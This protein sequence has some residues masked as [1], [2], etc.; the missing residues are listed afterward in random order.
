VYLGAYDTPE[1][2]ASAYDRAALAYWGE[3]AQLNVSTRLLTVFACLQDHNLSI[4][5]EM[6]GYY[7]IMWQLAYVACFARQ[8]SNSNAHICCPVLW[9][10]PSWVNRQLSP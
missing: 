6:V 2:A 5:G 3:A 8:A 1:A 10:Q 9:M 4:L 7:V